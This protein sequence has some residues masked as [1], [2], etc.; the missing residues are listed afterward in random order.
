[1]TNYAR[2]VSLVSSLSARVAHRISPSFTSTLLLF[3]QMSVV[4]I[5]GFLLLID[6]KKVLPRHFKTDSQSSIPSEEPA[7]SEERIS[8]TVEEEDPPGGSWEPTINS[9]DPQSLPGNVNHLSQWNLST[10][11]RSS[12]ANPNED[13]SQDVIPTED[14]EEYVDV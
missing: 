3:L 1:M 10:G 14:D 7:P 6:K 12:S 2:T 13:D 4:I 9:S 5:I 11:S 8:W